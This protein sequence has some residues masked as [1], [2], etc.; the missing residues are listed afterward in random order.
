MKNFLKIAV[1]AMALSATACSKDDDNVYVNMPSAKIEAENN[2]ALL[3][4]D[5]ANAATPSMVENNVTI[6]NEATVGDA[7][8]VTISLDLVHTFATDLIVQLVSPSGEICTLIKR[9]LFSADNPSTD[10]V[11]GNII[12]FNAN[13]FAGFGAIDGI[14][15]AGT[16]VP[17]EGINTV[18]QDL[19]ATDL[20]EFFNER[21]IKGIWKLR[22]FDYVQADTGKVNSWKITFDTGALK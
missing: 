18:P 1:I 16:Y 6:N 13:A 10:F 21:N 8:K 15:Q 3:I 4:P 14:V 2:N 11:S 19:H 9:P 5:A 7:S 17:T 22:V 12:S 20:S